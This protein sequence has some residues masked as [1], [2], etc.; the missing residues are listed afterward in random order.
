L[1]PSQRCNVQTFN[2]EGTKPDYGK[3]VIA[4]KP[5]TDTDTALKNGAK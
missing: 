1:L 4:L 2:T 5:H 3:V